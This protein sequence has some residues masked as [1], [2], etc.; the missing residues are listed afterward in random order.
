VKVGDGRAVFNALMKQGIIIRDMTAYKLPQWIRVSVGT[1]E[2]NR[3]F[4]SALAALLSS[5]L[6][7]LK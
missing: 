5:P 6:P 7:E 3:R 2:Q 1:M 4:V